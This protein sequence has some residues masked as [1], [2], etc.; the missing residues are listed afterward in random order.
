[1]RDTV[2]IT[3]MGYLDS[4]IDLRD[5]TAHDNPRQNRIL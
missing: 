2:C 5:S 4:V 3:F 1:M